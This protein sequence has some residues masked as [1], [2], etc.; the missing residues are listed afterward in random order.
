MG[1][2]S[3]RS[4]TMVYNKS[5]NTINLSATNDMLNS[6]MMETIKNTMSTAQNNCSS[7]FTAS[8]K[9]KISNIVSLG[10]LEISDLTVDSK[11]VV[12][13]ECLSQQQLQTQA[14]DNFMNDNSSQM[15]T[16]LASVANTDFINNISGSLKNKVDS[17]PLSFTSSS[18]DT[19]VTNIQQTDVA[20]NMMQNIR[21]IYKN[22][23]VNSTT[24]EA[25]NNAYTSFTAETVIDVS[26][27]TLAAG[28]K[29]K[30]IRLDSLNKFDSYAKLSQAISQVF[31]QKMEN[32]LGMKIAFSSDTKQTSANSSV[33]AQSSDNSV[34]NDTAI[35]TTGNVVN[36][37]VDKTTGV[38]N[39]AVDKTTGV[40]NNISRIPVIIGGIIGT[41]I[42]IIIIAVII[43]VIIKT[44]KKTTPLIM[45]PPP[46]PMM[47]M[48][49]DSVAKN[50]YGDVIDNL[51]SIG[52]KYI[53][54]DTLYTLKNS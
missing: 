9:L 21:N 30:A 20:L 45:M 18:A 25:V 42:L 53:Q 26:D 43:L 4:N 37:T 7:Q 41:V 5:T 6:A 32:I 54:E 40:M 34:T 48:M 47:P 33:T 24:Q 17:A 35:K 22:T 10:Y 16:M 14:E 12:R 1:G 50:G 36:N 46:P 23:S 52:N 2:G 3:S 15:Q 44:K 29:I 38:V 27:L 8:T 31:I 28:G 19:N 11:N 39:N 51:L 49:S 13:L